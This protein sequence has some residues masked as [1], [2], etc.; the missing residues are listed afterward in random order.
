[1]GAF[2]PRLQKLCV[3]GAAG[4][5]GPVL[6]GWALC[7]GAVF[8]HTVL[9]GGPPR[10]QVLNEQ[11]AR[12]ASPGSRVQGGQ[13]AGFGVWKRCG[14][15]DMGV[16]EQSK[17]AAPPPLCSI[18]HLGT[19]M[20]PAGGVTWDA[21]TEA[22]PLVVENDGIVD[23]SFVFW[24]ELSDKAGHPCCPLGSHCCGVRVGSAVGVG[25]FEWPQCKLG[26]KG[27][28]SPTLRAR[29]MQP[30]TNTLQ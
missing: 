29:G 6:W 4:L 21:G 26:L 14:C 18:L 24:S 15:G 17:A 11:C 13:Q 12:L 2:N 28:S 16:L 23:K 9:L 30:R 5:W 7:A 20:C 3:R 10:L 22:E 27:T 8:Q 1:M 19:R 25:T